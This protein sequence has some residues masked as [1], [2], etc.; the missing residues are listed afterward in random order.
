ML[1]TAAVLFGWGSWEDATVQKT[2]GGVRR[3]SLPRNEMGS[4]DSAL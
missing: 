2:Y 3:I 1:R 4:E